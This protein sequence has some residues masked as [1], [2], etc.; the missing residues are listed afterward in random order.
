M[1]ILTVLLVLV[2]VGLGLWAINKFVPMDARIKSI[3]NVVAIVAV[4][5]WLL[6]V[7]GV[8][9]ALGGATI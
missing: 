1:S 9:K 4:I 2:L 7:F 3:L 6:K 8:F 5:L